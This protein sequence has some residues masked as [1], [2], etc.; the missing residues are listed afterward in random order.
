M[1]HDFNNL[2]TVIASAGRSLRVSAGAAGAVASTELEVA[3]VHAAA[4]TKSLLAYARREAIA[5]TILSVDAVID[6]ALPILT[7][8]VEPDLRLSVDLAAPSARVVIDAAQLRQVTI[9]LVSNAV[10]ATR[11]HGG[12]IRL[13]TN[14]VVLETD[15]ARARGLVAEGTFLVLTVADDGRGMRPDLLARV[16]EPFFTTKPQGEGTGLGLALCVSIVKRAGGFIS[17]DSQPSQGATFRVYLPV[18]RTEHAPAPVR[19][20]SPAAEP[21]PVLYAATVLVVEDNEPIRNLVTRVLSSEGLR[22]LEAETLIEA[23]AHLAAGKVDLLLVD[24]RLP[25]GSGLDLVK[26]VVANRL[27]RHVV[28]MSGD[29]SDEPEVPVSA[30]LPKPFRVEILVETVLRILRTG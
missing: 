3:V 19:A 1:A 30:V 11:G 15:Q 12:Q 16:F 21:T 2:L 14:L 22:V 13:S 29:S 18:A 20:S 26:E 8:L 24:G 9:N 7:K 27:V 5:P 4:L 23:R 25:D 6:G 28:L 10:D 17:L